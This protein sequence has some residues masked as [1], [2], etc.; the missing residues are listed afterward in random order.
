M[1][2]SAPSEGAAFA[3]GVRVA[4]LVIATGYLI[5]FV[6]GP[7]AGAIGG[8]ALVT[9]GRGLLVDRAHEALLGVALALIAGAVAVAALR[10]GSLTLIEIRGA[11]AVLGP[12][13]MV[14]P[15]QAA[16]GA[17]LAVTGAAFA[18][19]AWQAATL[20][21]SGLGPLEAAEIAVAGFAVASVYWGPTF[22]A[23]GLGG[24]LAQAAMWLGTTAVIAA[25]AIGISLV[26]RSRPV[27]WTWGLLGAAAVVIALGAGLTVG[28]V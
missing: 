18:L 19:G 23:E 27:I 10:W 24:F 9:L 6:T 8:L 25:A 16:L 1:S 4:G 20:R 5:G 28:A 15:T 3:V 13:L 21:R 22:V 7:I 11:Q 2:D 12:T 26:L 14:G 17:G